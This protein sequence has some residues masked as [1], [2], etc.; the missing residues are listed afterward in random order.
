[1]L[2]TVIILSAPI[3]QNITCTQVDMLSCCLFTGYRVTSSLTS[4]LA[5]AAIIFVLIMMSRL[6]I[7]I[8]SSEVPNVWGHN[9]VRFWIESWSC[10]C[11]FCFSTS[12]SAFGVVTSYIKCAFYCCYARYLLWPLKRNAAEKCWTQRMKSNDI[13]DDVDIFQRV[14]G[15][16][17]FGQW[18]CM[19]NEQETTKY[20]YVWNKCLTDGPNKSTNNGKSEI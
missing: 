4:S 1:M 6:W 14:I 3:S 19:Q 10:Y 11:V 2:V 18:T 5:P 17:Y 9:T 15:K 8:I 12:L 7:L 20:S 16:T 13:R